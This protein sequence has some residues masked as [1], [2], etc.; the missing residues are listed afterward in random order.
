MPVRKFRR[1]EDMPAPWL[2]PGDP[3]LYLAIAGVWDFGQRLGS[4]RFPPGVYKHRTLEDMNR[5]DEA[6]AKA[7]FRAFWERRGGGPSAD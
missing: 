5:L 4:P 6:W 7:N 3:A 1:V 2:E